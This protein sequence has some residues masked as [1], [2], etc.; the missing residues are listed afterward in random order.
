MPPLSPSPEPEQEG[1]AADRAASTSAK[2][3][4]VEG[5]GEGDEGDADADGETEAATT[6]AGTRATSPTSTAAFADGAPAQAPPA[7]VIHPPSAANSESEATPSAAPSPKAAP[8]LLAPTTAA[9]SKP[10]TVA[11]VAETTPTASTSALPYGVG[12]TLTPSPTPAPSTTPQPATISPSL[13][14]GAP[15]T[16]TSS[17]VGAY[18]SLF[19]IP[20]ISS[21]YPSTLPELPSEVLRNRLNSSVRKK[22]KEKALQAPPPDL[23]KMHIKAQHTGAKNFLGRGKRVHNV[24]STHDWSVSG[25]ALSLFLAGALSA[26]ARREL[27]PS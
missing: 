20:E 11:A 26:C 21:H 5:E 3:S 16:S 18:T 13:L 4:E 1:A 10:T 25:L 15:S 24:L 17:S 8:A 2:A 27:T 6:A 19:G 7:M 23:Y 12:A 9:G 14:A 22:G